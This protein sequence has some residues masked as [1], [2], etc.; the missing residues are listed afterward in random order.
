[1]SVIMSILVCIMCI[2][3]DHNS[4]VHSL[5]QVTRV[6]VVDLFPSS[7]NPDNVPGS[8]YNVSDLDD[9]EPLDTLTISQHLDESS[10]P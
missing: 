2:I 9:F 8:L 5:A 7:Y 4:N 10:T 6:E 1:M 3:I